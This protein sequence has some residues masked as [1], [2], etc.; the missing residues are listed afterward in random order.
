MAPKPL[1]PALWLTAKQMMSKQLRILHPDDSLRTVVRYCQ[2]SK[3][4]TLPVVDKNES[5]I[6]VFPKKMLY[7]ALLDGSS[8]DDP[9][10]PYIVHN[11]V[12]I[13]S[14]LTYD[15]LS[16]AVRVKRSR[17]AYVPVV[18]HSGTVVG[19]LGTPEY[20]WS[21]LNVIM[22]SS[23]LLESL[24]RANYEVVIII[25]NDGYILRMN[26]AAEKIFGINLAEIKGMSL[27][28]VFPEITVSDERRQV[29]KQIVRSIPVIVNQVPILAEDNVQIGT[30]ITLLAIWEAEN[31]AR[32]LEIVRELHTTLGGVLS[33]S[34]DGVFVTDISGTIR[35]ANEAA[36]R[37]VSQTPEETIG[38]PLDKLLWTDGR[39]Q[40]AR[41]GTP[42]VETCK[43]NGRD[44][45][46]S[47]VPIMRKDAEAKEV[48]GV[49]S[50]IF[51]D[52]RLPKEIA[53]K[54]LALEQ[55]VR[56]YQS[57]LEKR[58]G[59]IGFDQIVSHNPAFN[60]MKREAKFTARSS[61][62]ILL[63]GESG[64]G[65]D[66]FA[67]A[68]HVA[69]PKAKK[70]FVEVNCAAIP[71]TLFESE[72]FGY[73]PGAFTGAS[74]QGKTGF[75]EQAHEGTIFLNEI[76]DMPLS[77]QVKILQVL[78]E[79]QFI[80]VGGT[81]T[82]KVDVRIVSATNR[83]L[84]EAIAR[85]TFREDLFYRLNVIEFRLPPLRERPEDILPLA[86]V[87]IEKYNRILGSNV[88]GMSQEVKEA[89]LRN[90]WP[91]NVR[92][93]ENAIERAA[94]FVWQGE[95]GIEH[96][97]PHLFRSEKGHLESPPLSLYRQTLSNIDKEI[98]LNA[99]KK[100]NGNKSAAA[101]LLNVSRSVFYDKLAKYGL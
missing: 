61:S 1:N 41:N 45:I 92:E 86:E 20:L 68:I 11:P 93:L 12:S 49:V 70:P 23:A 34:S 81:S 97:P 7:R 77:I 85:G 39:A 64:T 33:A 67:R 51:L 27:S 73:A 35:Y 99:L 14:D 8:L 25:D 42:E 3:L 94:N 6:G 80:R 16:L 37:L 5:L 26:P 98:I 44:R 2:E 57:E 83:N 47:H 46:V 101:R 71:E 55:Q 19:M 10:A 60:V 21:T 84:Q 75:F 38:M 4:N 13:S 36:R 88:T 95:I 91:G 40:A 50:N 65:K 66:M 22:A 76:G 29:M 24:F 15:E 31:I 17:V 69:S 72:L 87:F 53:Q 90:N 54:W 82:Q 30:S 62:T 59:S 63:T 74:R 56:Y 32:E 9:C 100:A 28:E 52:D 78:Q 48:T 18:D 89:L 58:G 79:K 96:L 43:I